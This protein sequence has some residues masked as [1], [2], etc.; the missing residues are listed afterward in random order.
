[1][2]PCNGLAFCPSGHSH[3]RLQIPKLGAQQSYETID[4]N[5]LLF[6]YSTTTD[7]WSDFWFRIMPSMT[8]SSDASFIIVQ[9]MLGVKGSCACKWMP[10]W[11]CIHFELLST[12][13]RLPFIYT[14]K[15]YATSSIHITKTVLTSLRWMTFWWLPYRKRI[16]KKE[17]MLVSL[18]Y[19]LSNKAQ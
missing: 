19:N 7:F 5:R 16:W 13:I 1:M 12:C 9:S 11:L 2:T 4:P 14:L 6:Y 10:C 15:D 18:C 3:F 17:Q 8:V